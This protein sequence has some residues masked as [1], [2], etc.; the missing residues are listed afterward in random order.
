LSCVEDTVLEREAERPTDRYAV[1]QPTNP[2]SP[3]F[4][5]RRRVVFAAIFDDL[6]RTS[7]DPAE[8]EVAQAEARYL[9]KAALSD[10]ADK[11][12][13][14]RVSRGRGGELSRRD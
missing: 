11:D 8:K 3:A 10:H 9:A 4:A 13:G 6:A 1:H 12:Y 2:S 7:E 14:D 5:R